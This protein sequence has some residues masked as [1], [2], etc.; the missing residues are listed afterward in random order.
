MTSFLHNGANTRTGHWRIIHRDSPGG[1]AWTLRRSELSLFIVIRQV[2]PIN[3]APG[4][5]VCY[6]RL[7]CWRLRV[8]LRVFMPGVGVPGDVGSTGFTGPSGFS[9]QQGWSR[10]CIRPHRTEMNVGWVIPCAGL[11]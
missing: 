3:C 7:P 2:A 11:C 5:E 9:G 8:T 1:A 4:D 10:L 6:L